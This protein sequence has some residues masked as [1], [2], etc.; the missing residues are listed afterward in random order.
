MATENPNPLFEEQFATTLA[1]LT[2]TAR[3]EKK[4]IL[5]MEYAMRCLPGPACWDTDEDGGL[6]NMVVVKLGPQGQYLQPV[7]II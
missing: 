2:E 7:Q 1:L 6:A 3:K 4:G 5:E